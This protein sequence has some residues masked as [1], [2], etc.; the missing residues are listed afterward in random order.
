VPSFLNFDNLVVWSGITD[1]AITIDLQLVKLNAAHK[2]RIDEYLSVAG[3]V[4]L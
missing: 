3:K 4:E 1:E 2:E